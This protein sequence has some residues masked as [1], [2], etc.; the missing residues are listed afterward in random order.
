MKPILCATLLM[1]LPFVAVSAAMTKTAPQLPTRTI[2]VQAAHLTTRIEWTQFPKLNYSNADLQ[3][4]DRSAVIRIYANAQG[5]IEQASIQDS[6][7]FAPLDQLLLSA[8][9]AAEVR[10]Y[11]E[12]KTALPVIGYQVF[13]LQLMENEQNDCVYSFNSKNWQAQQQGQPTRFQYLSRPVLE[14]DTEQLKG[15][16]RKLG[17]KIKANRKGQ[18]EKV[19][20]QKGSGNYVLDQQV[21]SALKGTQI[22]TQRLARTLWLYKPSSFKDEIEFKLAECD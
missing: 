5:Q 21:F 20:I 12:N 9:K 10:P 3:G 6:T 11:M 4:Q 14:L 15:Y 8:V 18:I 22:S 7:G 16:D 19:K 1:S 13:N 2:D 17:F